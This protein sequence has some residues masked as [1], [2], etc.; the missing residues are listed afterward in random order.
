MAFFELSSVYMLR[1]QQPADTDSAIDMQEFETRNEAQ[2]SCLQKEVAALKV[3][4]NTTLAIQ[5]RREAADSYLHNA[6]VRLSSNLLTLTR[7][8]LCPRSMR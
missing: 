1:Q 5:Y 3:Q 6:M 7:S 4:L 8:K 2:M